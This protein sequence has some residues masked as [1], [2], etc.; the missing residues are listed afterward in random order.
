ML[1]AGY[2]C[3]CDSTPLHTRDNIQ[4]KI[5]TTTQPVE[6]GF[7]LSYRGVFNDSNAN[8]TVSPQIYKTTAREPALNWIHHSRIRHRGW[9]MMVRHPNHLDRLL[10][11]RRASNVTS[12]T[13][14][15]L[16]LIRRTASP[17][18]GRLAAAL[19]HL[20]Q[21]PDDLGRVLEGVV[22][23]A[24]L[25]VVHVRDGLL[26]QMPARG[27]V[28]DA[29]V[30]VGGVLELDGE[31]ERVRAREEPL[32]QCSGVVE[33]GG[34][35]GD[36]VDGRKEERRRWFGRLGR[37]WAKP[38][39]MACGLACWFWAGRGWDHVAV[40]LEGESRAL[41]RLVGRAAAAD[42]VGQRGVAREA[43]DPRAVDGRLVVEQDENVVE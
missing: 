5:A 22:V 6:P 13:P 15:R 4:D 41:V 35:G 23:H 38:W 9:H 17:R 30:Q 33:A 12:T 37:A 36:I 20:A 29:V 28:V 14:T 10:G 7:N 40:H 25:R 34:C 1:V 32:G 3:M 27:L 42:A 19:D 18:A 39:G 21:D 31:A 11:P 16:G 26:G 43:D 24:L 8:N 2:V